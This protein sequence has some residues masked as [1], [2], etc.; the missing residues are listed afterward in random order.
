[1]GWYLF[2]AALWGVFGSSLWLVGMFTDSDV[3]KVQGPV[4]MGVAVIICAVVQCYDSIIKRIEASERNR[5]YW[6]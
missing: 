2:V 1:M 6:R 5:D 4:F 3:M